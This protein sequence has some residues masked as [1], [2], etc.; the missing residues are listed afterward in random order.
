M[1]NN[2]KT[3]VTND[4]RFNVRYIDTDVNGINDRMV[5][6]VPKLSEQEFGI[7][8]DIKI[9]NVQSFP[10]VGGNWTVYFNTTGIANLRIKQWN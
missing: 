6:T 2:S 1:V 8:A 7:D 3:D 5:W 10:S 4:P 9:I